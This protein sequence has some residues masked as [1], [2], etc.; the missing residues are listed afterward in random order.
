MMEKWIKRIDLDFPYLCLVGKMEKWRKRNIFCL[1]EMIN[2][3]LENEVGINLPLY[4]Y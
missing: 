2:K 3:R 4:P 1:V